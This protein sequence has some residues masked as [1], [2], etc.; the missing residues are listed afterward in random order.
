MGTNLSNTREGNIGGGKQISAKHN[1][2]ETFNGNQGW[3]Q[4]SQYKFWLENYKEAF[5]DMKYDITNL[6]K[7]GGKEIKL[8]T[9]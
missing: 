9:G 5:K 7:E 3:P 6:N 2:Y 1:D 4:S 8:R